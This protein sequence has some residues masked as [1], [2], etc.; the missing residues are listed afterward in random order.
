MSLKGFHIVFI[1]L[2]VLVSLLFAWW[3]LATSSGQAAGD[4]VRWTGIFSGILGIALAI[5]GIWFAKV[6][7]NKIIV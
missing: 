4:L 2:A 7:R 3:S 5:Y 6:K 1:I